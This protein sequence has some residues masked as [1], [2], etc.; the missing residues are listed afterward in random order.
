MKYYRVKNQVDT[1]EVGKNIYPQTDG[2]VGKDTFSSEHCYTKFTH[3]NLPENF[4]PIEKIKLANSANQTD[5]LSTTLISGFGFIVS[6]KMKLILEQHNIVN[7][8]F[9]KIPI[10]HQQ[11]E[12][13][14]YYWFQM[15]EPKQG[16]VDF[17]KSTFQVRR[18]RRIIKDEIKFSSIDNYWEERKNYKPGELFRTK[19]VVINPD[20]YDFLYL[21]VGGTEFLI[22]EKIMNVMLDNNITGYEITELEN[23]TI[24]DN[25]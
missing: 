9:Y 7:H 22:S 18:F 17:E 10:V 13:D 2:L 14:K 11:Q 16:Y 15:Y 24:K 1:E 3:Y 23:I 25:R 4:T 5:F 8:R 20:E 21:S 19:N 12:L 6:N